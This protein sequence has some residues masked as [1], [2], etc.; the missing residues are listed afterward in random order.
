MMMNIVQ[1]HVLNL[2]PSFYYIFVLSSAPVCIVSAPIMCS[3]KGIKIDG[4]REEIDI[5]K[6]VLP[7]RALNH[8]L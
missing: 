6:Y 3:D 5:K 8:R 2:L 4:R 7:F 1:L